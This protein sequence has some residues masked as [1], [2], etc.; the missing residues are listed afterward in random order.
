M[1]QQ[2]LRDEML[3]RGLGDPEIQA[4]AH[5]DESDEDGSG[6]DPENP[7]LA[8]AELRAQNTDANEWWVR[9]FESDDRELA[10][11][12]AIML[13]N[14]GI[15]HRWR[16]EPV[17]GNVI[18][19][20]AEQAEEAQRVLARPIPQSVIAESKEEVPEYQ[21]P[22]CPRCQNQEPTLIATEPSNQWLCESCG[23]E[24]T[25]PIA[26]SKPL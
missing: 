8:A 2:A 25:D 26:E 17:G 23:N 9:V 16:I 3:Q 4:E 24:W 11:Q 18:E 6:H 7:L 13:S 14:A 20:A 10:E 5:R 22:H 19:A 1:A 15:L 12:Y 21:L